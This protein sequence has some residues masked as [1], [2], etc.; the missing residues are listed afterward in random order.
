MKKLTFPSFLAGIFM[1]FS[2]L[3]ANP[4]QGA[5]GD[6][7]VGDASG[8]SSNIIQITQAGVRTLY[9]QGVGKP[10]ALFF[11]PSGYLFAK[12][13]AANSIYRIAPI[14]KLNRLFA[15]NNFGASLA[16]DRSGNVF[17]QDS[18]STILKFDPTGVRTTFATG[19]GTIQD[20]A[21]DQLGNLYSSDSNAG[22]VYK[23]TPQG[24]R[25]NAA[26]GLPFPTAL[27][28]DRFGNLFVFELL[29]KT[30]YKY[31]PDGTRT[32]FA[33]S[34]NSQNLLDMVC[35]EDGSLF[36]VATDGTTTMP[37]PA[38]SIVKFTP[39]GAV[40][41]RLT[42]FENLTSITI[43]PPTGLPLNVSTR[44]GVQTGDKA[45]IAGV[46]ISGTGTKRLIFR[47]IGPSLGAAG[48]T[49]ALQDTT[50]ELIQRR[51]ADGF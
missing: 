45:A 17:A 35:A 6:I 9:F 4:A 1:L 26:I 15:T 46:I 5:A 34:P 27:A 42:G 22:V 41:P 31:A 13:A 25:S 49:G 7:F 8:N 18:T 11:D 50:L 10:T 36:A 48:V 19:N 23:F 30:I 32:V 14:T 16:V 43:E 29:G 40:G 21:F 3:S 37:A 51:R 39:Q 47:G 24:V 20:L 28:T 38:T 44:V 12:D 2:G 33:T